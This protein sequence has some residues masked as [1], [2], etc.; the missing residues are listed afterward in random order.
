M[1]TVGMQEDR[2]ISLMGL[3]TR[4]VNHA[5]S[6][7][8]LYSRSDGRGNICTEALTSIGGTIRHWTSEGNCGLAAAQ[9][10]REQRS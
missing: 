1:A 2:A 5:E 4:I 7:T 3:P 9:A 6:R 10:K 8:L